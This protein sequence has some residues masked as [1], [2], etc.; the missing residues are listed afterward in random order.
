M[1]A[2]PGRTPISAGKTVD[3]VRDKHAAHIS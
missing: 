2:R 3:A 1:E